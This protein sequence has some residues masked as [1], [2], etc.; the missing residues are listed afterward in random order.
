MCCGTFSP[1]ERKYPRVSALL[2]V[3]MSMSGCISTER[4]IRWAVLQSGAQHGP[5]KTQ[6][7]QMQR[8]A[9]GIGGKRRM[10]TYYFRG[11]GEV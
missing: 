8:R 10:S 9:P 6:H 5:P 4:Y 1:A 2:C 3:Y 7:M 11:F